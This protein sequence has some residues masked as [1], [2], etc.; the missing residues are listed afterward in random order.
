MDM[1]KSYVLSNVFAGRGAYAGLAG[2]EAYSAATKA[3]SD[4]IAAGHITRDLKAVTESGRA[5]LLNGE[6]SNN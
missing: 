3:C 5:T 4:L 2:G 6:P 1:M